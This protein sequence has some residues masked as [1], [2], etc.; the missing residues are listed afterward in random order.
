LQHAWPGIQIARVPPEEVPVEVPPHKFPTWEG[1][2][3]LIME[4]PD[5][6]GNES[7]LVVPSRC[8]FRLPFFLVLIPVPVSLSRC[9]Q[10]EVARLPYSPRFACQVA[11]QLD[12][13]L[14]S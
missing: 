13:V 3:F 4:I 7:K 10:S 9:W 6:L 14:G 2:P 12:Q 5:E 1:D 11:D 8:F